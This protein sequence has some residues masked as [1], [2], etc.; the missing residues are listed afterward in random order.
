M[1]IISMGKNIAAKVEWTGEQGVIKECQNQAHRKVKSFKKMAF[2]C[3]PKILLC[4]SI[5]Y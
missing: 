5:D 3:R 1:T 4:L 2:L